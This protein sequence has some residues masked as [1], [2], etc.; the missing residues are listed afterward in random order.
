[1]EPEGNDNQGTAAQA[2]VDRL[3]HVEVGEGITHDRMTIF[4]VFGNDTAGGPAVRP[5]LQYRTLAEALGEGWVKV[6]EMPSA[7][8]PEL[9]L[10]NTGQV[11]VL[12]LDGEEIVGGKQNRIVNASFLVAAGVTLTLPVTCVEHGRW[13]DI[14]PVFSSGEASYFSL[15]QAKHMQVA[16]SL[17]AVGSPHTAQGEIWAAVA[18]T[19]TARRTSSPT[20]A[21]H[22]IYRQRNED[23]TTY[24][25]AFPYVP[26]AIGAIL[27]MNGQVAG[28][29]LF[30]QPRTAETLWPR[31]VRSYALDALDGRSGAPST[32]DQARALLARA[33]TARAEVYP[34]L[35]LGEDVRLEGDGVVGGALVY[36]HLPI[37]LNLFGTH[38]DPTITEGRIARSSIRRGFQHTQARQPR[39]DEQP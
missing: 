4:P 35:A 26:G 23:I 32:R 21:M 34:S 20:G 28:A 30:D 5:P 7:S 16:Q 31:L 25:Q 13:H 33:R 38:G 18:E 36:D 22:D 6:V 11:M 27:A 2:V 3:G 1:M 19:I 37:H 15:R 9:V 14:S 24:Q 10:Q 8:V 39:Q 17:R 12:V 29:D